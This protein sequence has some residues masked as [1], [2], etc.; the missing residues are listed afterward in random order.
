MIITIG[1][2]VLCAIALSIC[3][4]CCRGGSPRRTCEETER[5]QDDAPNMVGK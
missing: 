5:S 1:A 3:A 4:V 2:I